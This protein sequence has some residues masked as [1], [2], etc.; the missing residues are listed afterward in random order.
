MFEAFFGG[1]GGGQ[2]GGFGMGG[3]GGGA[4]RGR[5]GGGKARKATR[6]APAEPEAIE[7]ELDITFMTAAKGGTEPL[8]LSTEGK[9]R[10]IE[11]KIPR[12]TPDGARLRVRGGADGQDIILR[13]KVGPHPLFRR[14]E[15][16]VGPQGLDLYLDLPLSIA[17]AT[18]G[19]H[20]TVPTL[21]GSVELRI[22]PGTGS[23]R[24]LRVRG[25]GLED[26]KGARGDL[27]AIIKIVPPTGEALS[28][29]DAAA[30]RRIAEAGP[31]PRADWPGQA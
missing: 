7:H 14:T 12:G 9:A 13:I 10:T 6:A 28:P 31:N 19:A 11:V 24:K 27:Y 5:T 4:P 29:Q 23:G 15:H 20:V 25:Q 1:K 22:P 8:R 16:G 2:G 18:L 26:A 17:E 30:L 21:D 3:M